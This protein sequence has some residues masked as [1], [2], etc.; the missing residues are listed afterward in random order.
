MENNLKTLDVLITE[1][2]DA[3]DLGEFEVYADS[4]MLCFEDEHGSGLM[5]A[6]EGDKVSEVGFGGRKTFRF[7]ISSA[8]RCGLIFTGTD[9]IVNTI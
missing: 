6:V 9:F 4:N 2:A 3:S 5:Y 8:N 7:S 1:A